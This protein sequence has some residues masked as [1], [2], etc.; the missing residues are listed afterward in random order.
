M[1]KRDYYEILGVRRDATEKEI[2]SA[3]RRLARQYHPDVNPGDR[4]AEE[5]FK[6]INAAYEV[7]K[8]PEKR[9]K[10]DKYGDKWE[11]ADQIE[12]QQRRAGGHDFFRRTGTRTTGG[13]FDFGDFDFDRGNLGGF[14]DI[15]GGLFRRGR[16]TARRAKGENLEHPVEITLEEAYHGTARTIELRVPETCTACG[17]TGRVAGG[18][19]AVCG[20]LGSQVKTQRLEVKIPPG[21]DTGSKVRVAGKGHP[22]VGG[23]EPGDLLLVITVRPHERFER[24]GDDLYVDV[25]APLFDLVLGGEVEVPTP[26]GTRLRLKVPA[27]TQNGRTFRLGGQGMPR[28]GSPEHKGDLYARVKAVLPTDLTPRERE[29]FEELRRMRSGAAAGAV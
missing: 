29:L 26:K 18:P 22:G 24:R 13:P 25:P 5:K 14:E 1:A 11:L 10:Y 16:P 19:C 23:G 8:D 6:E 20:G 4:A 15:L 21:V 12:E 17:G 9:R 28:L 2:R 27:G 7:L 3:Y